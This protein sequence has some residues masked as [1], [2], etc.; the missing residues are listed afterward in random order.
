MTTIADITAHLERW[1]PL[2]YQESYDN[3]GLLVGEADRPAA[4]VLVTLDVTEAVIEEAVRRDCNLVVA[5]HPL[6][7]KGLRQVNRRSYVG[8]A[9]VAA[10][11]HNVAVYAAHTNLDNVAGGVNFRIAERLGLENVR[12][13][14]PKR[15]TLKKLVVFVPQ[16]H[17]QELLDALHQVGAGRIGNYEGCSFRTSG[18][19]AFTP[20]DAADPHIG[21]SGR[22]EEVTEDRVEVMF[23]VPL[24]R[25]VLAA[26]REAHPY[27]EVAYYLTALENENQEV[28]AG[29]VGILPQPMAENAFLAFL[30]EKMPTKC[31]KHTALRQRPVQKVAVCG[32]AGIF[33]LPD[34]V[35]AGADVFVTSD[36]KYHEFFDA[37]GKLVLADIGHYESEVFTKDLIFEHL[38][39]RFTNIAV[40]LSETGTNPV[41]YA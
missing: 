24:T 2:A 37:D 35:R 21:E 4:G 7:F 38:S 19:G 14:A 12:I 27:E 23:P 10:V 18:T 16:V 36:V 39:K 8:R 15:Q 25:R 1:A 17:T 6:I 13:L 5:H 22:P 20:N 41:F 30:K 28:G 31:V 26:M 29:A 33:L 32:G 11:R 40:N 9:V 3:A 34:A